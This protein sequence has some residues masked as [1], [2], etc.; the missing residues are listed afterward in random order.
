MYVHAL[1]LNWIYGYCYVCINM[2]ACATAKLES[3]RT[4]GSKTPGEG[5]EDIRGVQ[6]SGQGAPPPPD[7]DPGGE[8]FLGCI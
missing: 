1:K 8:T 2:H 4:A 5:A 3:Q 7:P 6:K